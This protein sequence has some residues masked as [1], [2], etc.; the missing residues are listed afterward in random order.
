MADKPSRKTKSQVQ[1]RP[2]SQKLGIRPKMT[3]V[4]LV[5]R[6]AHLLEGSQTTQHSNAKSLHMRG[7]GNDFDDGNSLED[8]DDEF[9]I[10]K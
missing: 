7:L 4:N 1:E 5:N 8:D 9:A 6:V 10:K 3:E 2:Q